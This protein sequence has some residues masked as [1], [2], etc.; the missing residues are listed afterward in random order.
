MGQLKPISNNNYQL[1]YYF[2]S[3]RSLSNFS[4][5]RFNLLFRFFIT[6]RVITIDK[7]ITNRM[8]K[9][10]SWNNI[11]PE[12]M[13]AGTDVNMYKLTPPNCNLILHWTPDTDYFYLHKKH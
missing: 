2:L 12:L 4:S 10:N 8:Q 6:T 5:T 1:T 3:V 13:W 7:G 9:I 11:S